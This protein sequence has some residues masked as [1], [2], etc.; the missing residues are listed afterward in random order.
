MIRNKTFVSLIIIF[1]LASTV[2]M[3][4]SSSGGSSDP[5]QDPVELKT[6]E[7]T[8]ASH[9]F[10]NVTV[11]NSPAP[12]EVWLT[13]GSS[14][15][16]VV[17][18]RVLSDT[19]NFALDTSG[20]TSPCNTETP[21]LA[22]GEGCTV[23]VTF[24]PSS[25][26]SLEGTLTI[27]SNDTDNPAIDVAL[28]GMGDPISGLQVKINQVETECPEVTAYVSVTDQK[29]Y[30]LTD[31]LEDD[32]TVEEDGSP[33]TPL[34]SFTYVSEITTPVSVALAMDYSG[35][36]SRTEGAIENMEAGAI[37]FIS[38][39]RVDDEAEIINFDN[40]VEVVQE[41]T[42]DKAALTS[43][44]TTSWDKGVYT[45]LYDAIYKAIEDTSVK[46]DSRRAVI[47]I[48]DGT[49]FPHVDN[50]SNYTLT[51]IIDYAITQGVPVFTVGLGDGI[52]P[53]ILKQ[54]A[55]DTGGQFYDATLPYDIKTIYQQL[56]NVLLLNQYVLTYD[57]GLGVGATG[58]LF[59]EAV[60]QGIN[61]D[62]TM[63]I[64]PCP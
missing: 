44:V 29:G 21:T 15:E 35:S 47:V 42:S 26:S 48:T 54:I 31:L 38:Q 36:V 12:I 30:P 1:L 19:D 10:G 32:F 49:D 53:D 57:S 39:L 51:E 9:D 4:C 24:T 16:I 55:D 22:E 62:S 37:E 14:S 46:T 59:V 45:K 23:E 64:T 27:S 3:G 25:V 2:F 6:L 18:D 56:V 33:M 13:N 61:G 11:G 52:D 8:P 17:S 50:P 7:V 60:F 58:D 28:S 34:K 41:F 40:V 43:A 63:E 20:G 5:A